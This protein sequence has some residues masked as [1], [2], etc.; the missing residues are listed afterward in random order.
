MSVV[1]EMNELKAELRDGMEQL[2]LE[3]EKL[4]AEVRAVRASQDLGT[5]QMQKIVV[6]ISEARGEMT[7]RFATLKPSDGDVVGASADGVRIGTRRFSW[8]AA[9]AAARI[10][11]AVLAGLLAAAGALAALLQR[12]GIRLEKH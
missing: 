5:E 9:W 7:G 1:A 6:L 4:A 10:G 8:G 3:V 12:F 11:L 2:R